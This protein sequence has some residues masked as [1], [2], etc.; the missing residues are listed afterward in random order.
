M[1]RTLR[2]SPAATSTSRPRRRLWP[3]VFF[4]SM[5]FSLVCRRSSL[6]VLVTRKRRVAPRWLFILGTGSPG[7]WRAHGSLPLG[8]ALGLAGR[9]HRD[10]VPSVLAG[11]AVDLGDL[12]EVGGQPLQQPPPELGVGH[13][14]AA[15][16]DGDLHLVALLEEPLDVALL[17]LVVVRVDL[18]PHLHLFE[19]HQALLAPG[20]LGLDGLLVL[21]LRVVHQ[22]DHRRTG[23]RGHLDHVEVL[24]A[25]HPQR[26]L[27]VHHPELLAVG[28]DHPDLGGPDPVVDPGLYAD[29]DIPPLGLRPNK[30]GGTRAAPPHLNRWCHYDPVGCWPR[31]EK[32]SLLLCSRYAVD[33]PERFSDPTESTLL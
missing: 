18:G 12:D 8:A 23:H 20:F 33:G 16:H 22:L 14:T 29:A 19:G 30:N 3:G 2:R 9:E 6:P 28:A 26:G 7:L 10:H 32:P 21:E 5:W 4:S 27:G 13:L 15:E 31:G 25:G 17:R 24:L 11:R 1:R